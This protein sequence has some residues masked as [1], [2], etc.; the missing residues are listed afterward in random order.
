MTLGTEKFEK[1]LN[2]LAAAVLLYKQ[3]AEDK[4]VDLSDIPHAIDFSKKLPEMIQD[5]KELSAVLEEIKDF[6]VTE[7]IALIGKVDAHVKQIEKA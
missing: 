2:H 4:K 7:I 6:D 5:F 1:I 3:V